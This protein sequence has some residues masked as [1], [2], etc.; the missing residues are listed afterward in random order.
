M[1]SSIVRGGRTFVLAVVLVAALGGCAALSGD[2][3]SSSAFSRAA[4]C[5][6][7][8]GRWH[9]AVAPYAFCEIRS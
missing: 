5:A 8:G 6:R 9:E 2:Q 7:N 4:E 1:T 3:P